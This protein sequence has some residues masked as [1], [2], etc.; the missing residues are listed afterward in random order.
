[1]WLVHIRDMNRANPHYHGIILEGG[2]DEDGNFVYLPVSDI[3]NMTELFR[4]L[5]I[6]FFKDKKLINDKFAR[7]LLSWKNNGF[8][9]DNSIIPN[10]V[11]QEVFCKT[12]NSI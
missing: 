9:I 10:G 1:M 12:L 6:K 7:N 3:K 2:F 4:R 8:S 5:V 11:Y